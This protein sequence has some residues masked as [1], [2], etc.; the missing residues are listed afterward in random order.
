MHPVERV[1]VTPTTVFLETGQDFNLTCMTQAGPMNMFQ[2]RHVSTSTILT[3]TLSTDMM[4]V[5]TVSNVMPVD[6]G[7][8]ECTVSNEVGSYNRTALVVGK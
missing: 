8:Y 6:Q 4:S 2:W 5:L 7:T 3:A 1:Q